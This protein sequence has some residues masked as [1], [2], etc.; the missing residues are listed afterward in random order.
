MALRALLPLLMLALEPV[1]AL[2]PIPRSYTSGNTSLFIAQDIPIRY[3]GGSVRWL[4]HSHGSFL[5]TQ[6]PDTKNDP[7]E[8]LAY[9]ADYEPSGFDATQMVDAAVSRTLGSI[10]TADFVPWM[11]QPRNKLSSFE[12]A[13]NAS[14]GSLSCLEI[15]L[16]GGSNTT[17][18]IVGTMD[19]S[20]NLTVTEDGIAKI[21]AT[22]SVGVMRG[23]ETFAQLFYQH[24]SEDAWYM[25]N[26]PVD[27]Q[28]SPRYSHRG[29]MIDTSRHFIK[30]TDIERTIDAMSWNKMNV[31]HVHV[32][33]SQSWPLE[34]PALP[35]LTA[36]GAY[37][38]SSIY[39]VDDIQSIQ[40]YGAYRGVEVYFEI[41]MP[42][43]IGVVAEAYPDLIAAYDAYPYFWYCAQPPCGALRLNDSDVEDFLGTLFDD[44]LPR[45]APYTSYFHTGGDE[46]NANGSMLDPGLKT[47]DTTILQPLVQSFIDSQHARVR[48]A[49]LIPMVWEEI[50]TTWNVTL[51]KDVVIQSWLGGTAIGDLTAAGHKVIDSDY[52]YWVRTAIYNRRRDLDT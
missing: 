43:H 39:S 48:A 52:N 26:A 2:W 49:G 50:P 36:K 29:V 30:L 35:E 25:V 46:Y 1:S 21:A 28:D 14:V 44:V 45:V 18:S 33:D 17:S 19:E 41:D 5:T 20:Y 38:K 7:R 4:L 13:S 11:L 10:F 16:S 23:L 24:S 9:Q 34:V 6:D 47:N 22:S 27:I 15:T 8:Q 3:N 31:L 37:S 32:T 40:E 51:G 42:G 12:P